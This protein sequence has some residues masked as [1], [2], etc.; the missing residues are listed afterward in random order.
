MN[1]LDQIP[2]VSNLSWSGLSSG[3]GFRGRT[4]EPKPLGHPGSARLVL[5]A[6]CSGS[7]GNPRPGPGPKPKRAAVSGATWG[8]GTSRRPK[9]T[10]AVGPGALGA[11]EKKERTPTSER[12]CGEATPWVLGQW[13]AGGSGEGKTTNPSQGTGS[14]NS[15]FAFFFRM[16]NGNRKDSHY[17]EQSVPQI[18]ARAF[19]FSRRAPTPKVP[20]S[21]NLP[22]L[23]KF[24]PPQQKSKKANLPPQTKTKHLILQDEVKS[25]KKGSVNTPAQNAR[26]VQKMWLMGVQAL[27]SQARAVDRGRR[28]GAFFFFFF[29]FFFAFFWKAPPH[30][31]KAVWWLRPS[32]RSWSAGNPHVGVSPF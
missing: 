10:G 1:K 18:F 8:K 9:N 27:V 20:P 30:S 22:T 23:P 6:G 12:F 16:G 17:L 2:E 29:F 25:L 21:P 13:G 7:H 26:L 3:V 15:C 14:Q 31:Q 19:Y 32:V 11:P 24:R 5:L 28:A 4:A